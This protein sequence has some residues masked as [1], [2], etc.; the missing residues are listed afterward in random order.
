MAQ[1]ERSQLVPGPA[2]SIR[3][4]EHKHPLS[5]PGQWGGGG[6]AWT[7]QVWP[8]HF[9]WAHG[10]DL[11]CSLPSHPHIRPGAPD[12]IPLPLYLSLPKLD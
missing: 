9:L 11:Q 2:P 7:Q 4:S 5:S 3:E 10:L 12:S 6:G 1:L 8:A